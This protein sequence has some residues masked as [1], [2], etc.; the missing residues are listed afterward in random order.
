MQASTPGVRA[1]L[2]WSLNTQKREAATCPASLRCQKLVRTPQNLEEVSEA[3]DEEY[4]PLCLRSGSRLG[5]ACIV[6]ADVK[7]VDS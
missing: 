1:D 7:T 5:P 4:E 3:K 6:N 2:V